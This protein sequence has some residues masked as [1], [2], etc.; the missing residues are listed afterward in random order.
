MNR[1]DL[2][3]RLKLCRDKCHPTGQAFE[4][5]VYNEA[6]AAL[7]PV[8]PEDVRKSLAIARE[9]I[10][11]GR[12]GRSF[13]TLIS[14]DT[15][16]ALCNIIERLAGDLAQ[17]QQSAFNPDWSLLEATQDSLREHMQLLKE[18]QQRIEELTAPVLPEDV[19]DELKRLAKFVDMPSYRA[20]RAEKAIDLIERQQQR[21]EKLERECGMWADNAREETKLVD[22][23]EI[24]VADL[25]R[26][27]CS[28][29]DCGWQKRGKE[30]HVQIA[31]YEKALAMFCDYELWQGRE[32]ATHTDFDY[33]MEFARTELERIRGMK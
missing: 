9:E 20:V 25:K 5:I 8:L 13:D 22:A 18:A 6:I 19:K 14:Q 3:E 1:D 32:D 24:K 16:D 33:A 21:I 23:L 26:Y 12:Y 10:H 31:E 17:F 11:Q 15:A 7:S 4:I 2:I 30:M 27:T 29:T 28:F